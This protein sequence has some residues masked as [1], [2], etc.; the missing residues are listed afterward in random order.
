MTAASRRWLSLYL[1]LLLA[2]SVLGALNQR[3]YWAQADLIA[4]KERLGLELQD[5]RRRSALVNGALAVR[6]WAYREGMT[7]ATEAKSVTV[8]PQ[9]APL[10]PVPTNGLELR[11]LWR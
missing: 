11:T 6:Q 5:L 2:L 7:P 8:A 10:P 4:H 3:T 9:S 1:A